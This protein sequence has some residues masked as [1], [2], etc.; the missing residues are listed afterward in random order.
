MNKTLF[1]AAFIT[2]G[3]LASVPVMADCG[4]T[5]VPEPGMLGLSGMAMLGLIAARYRK[6]KA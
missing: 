6:P 2:L 5:N 1:T 3:L 4:G